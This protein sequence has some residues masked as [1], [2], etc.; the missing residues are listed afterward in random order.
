MRISAARLIRETHRGLQ[1]FS[2]KTPKGYLNVIEHSEGFHELNN[3][4]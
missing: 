3:K 4:L 2:T 1:S